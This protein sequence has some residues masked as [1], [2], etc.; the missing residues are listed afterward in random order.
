MSA[1]ALL[2]FA[3]EYHGRG[4]SVLPITAGTKKPAL[5]NLREVKRAPADE[6]TIRDWFDRRDDLGIG[7]WMGPASG[8]LTCRDFDVREA[9]DRWKAAFPD[10]AKTLPTVATHRGFHVYGI[11]DHREITKLADGE[12]R[13]NGYCLLPP[14]I[15]PKGTPYRWVIWPMGEI[16]HLD[17]DDCGFLREWSARSGEDESEKRDLDLGCVTEHTEQTEQSPNIASM[18]SVPSVCSVTLSLADRINL[19]IAATL[20]RGEGQRNRQVFELARALK[21]IPSLADADVNDLRA[22]VEKW[23]AKA[24]PVIRTKAFEETWIDFLTAWPRIKFP[25][26]SEPLTQLF[27]QAAAVPPPPAAERYGIPELKLLVGLCEVLQRENGSA[28]FFLSCRT[29]GRLLN[30]DHNTAAR[31]LKLLQHDRLIVCVESGTK[32][33][34]ARYR[35]VGA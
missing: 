7:A 11:T 3:L 32:R 23:H 10:L 4:W 12:L 9:Y 1:T 5:H 6:H 33:K 20:P 2:T 22:Y 35:Y 8:G 25:R 31:W 24:L 19:A 29:A 13:A 27:Q 17:P 30:V 34:A 18:C 16:P 14:S 21:A 28:P 15:H 26:G